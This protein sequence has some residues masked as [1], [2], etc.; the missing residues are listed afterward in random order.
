MDI[1]AI[2]ILKAIMGTNNITVNMA[3]MVTVL[4]TEPSLKLRT[5]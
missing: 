4:A 5:S 2:P 1:K 3:I